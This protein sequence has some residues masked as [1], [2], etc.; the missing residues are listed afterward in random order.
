[1][2]LYAKRAYYETAL[3][4]R[5]IGCS[6][7]ICLL[8]H[9]RC[10]LRGDA[11]KRLRQWWANLCIFVGIFLFFGPGEFRYVGSDHGI[12]SN[13]EMRAYWMP[14]E[15]REGRYASWRELPRPLRGEHVSIRCMCI[16]LTGDAF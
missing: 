6:T 7:C 5:S 14:C 10:M 16:M 9:S 4:A 11:N 2:H 13:D 3:S 15:W 12:V 1:M 8:N